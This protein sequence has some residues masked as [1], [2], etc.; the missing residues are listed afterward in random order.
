MAVRQVSETLYDQLDSW[1]RSALNI[2][3]DTALTAVVD[4]FYQAA[5][6]D[7]R[8]S[9]FFEGADMEALKK[10][11]FNFMRYAFSEGRAGGY[12]GQQIG[13]AHSRLIRDLGL[14]ENHFDYVAEDLVATL[15]KFNVP[16]TI[17]DGVVAAVSPLRAS[18]VHA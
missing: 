9:R 4:E 17:V 5:L 14:N 6:A 10:H 12:S 15:N 11:Q 2:D 1:S 16:Q 8:L 3:G 18:F 13:H 7:E